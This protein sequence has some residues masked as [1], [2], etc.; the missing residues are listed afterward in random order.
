[1]RGLLLFFVLTYYPVLSQIDTLIACKPGNSTTNILDFSVED[2]LY[3]EVETASK[4]KEKIQD[5]PGIITLITGADIQKMDALN[6]LQV[7][8]RLVSV[9]ITGSVLFPENVISIRGD[10]TVHY[11]NHVL[12][13]INGRPLRESLGGGIR[14]AFYTQFPVSAIQKIEII[15]GPGSVLYGTGAFVGVVNV[16]TNKVEKNQLNAKVSAG[17][18]Q[19][20]QPQLHALLN[21]SNIS[22]NFAANAVNDNGWPFTAKDAS[23]AERTINMAQ[24]GV[25]GYL[26]VNTKQLTTQ[27]YYGKSQQNAMY[28][29]GAWNT[30]DVVNKN[31]DTLKNQP[32]DYV[33]DN[34]ICFADVGY[35][36]KVNQYWKSDVN[37]T[38]NYMKIN[39]LA[40][41]AVDDIARAS[42][43]DV[44][45]EITQY[46][47]LSRYTKWTAGAVVGYNSGRQVF[48]IS[49][50]LPKS[51]ENPLGLGGYFSYNIFNKNL[52]SNPNPYNII[53]PY[54]EWWQAGYLQ[55]E[56]FLT[57]KWKVVMGVQANKAPKILIDFVPRF[58]LL[59]NPNSQFTIKLLYGRAFRFAAANE[60]FIKVD[61]V[62]GNDK[63]IPEKIETVEWGTFW[64]NE[65][66]NIMIGNAFFYSRQFNRI[67]R[68]LQFLDSVRQ[69][70]AYTN[71][72]TRVSYGAEPEVTIG[73]A[74]KWQ[75]TMNALL[76]NSY[77]V[78]TS[79]ISFGE[80]QTTRIVNPQ[81]MPMYQIKV[82]C[83]WQ[84]ING[85][86]VNAFYGFF[87]NNAAT[88]ANKTTPVVNPS[89]SNMH[90]LNVSL[91]CKPQL[92]AKKG[93]INYYFSVSS[94]NV[95][96]QKMYMPD[97]QNRVNSIPARSGRVVY[98]H[99]GV[100]I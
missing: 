24:K 22:V 55:S 25:G 77:D 12:V 98:F 90:L 69:Q 75:W 29:G 6:L 50:T 14:M 86:G 96:N 93:K 100:S 76:M 45:A 68:N 64:Q 89:I 1:M 51:A 83:N 95:L 70:E 13:L 17:S 9:Y 71:E 58:T 66:G 78:Q 53:P 74:A 31:G 20:W 8:E 73:F 4:N 23:S 30:A 2:M 59:Y 5:A 18:F 49:V 40:V 67:A 87:G 85:V 36:F 79:T 94:Q 62:Q 56:I 26:A 61:F 80:T 43:N 7:L 33:A 99:V 91:N 21:K 39:E 35:Q 10:A 46:F 38:Y 47:Q 37:I 48:P 60:R 54:G 97:L 42:T 88:P 44:Q 19:R 72:G 84:P 81:R 15:R 92:L 28:F 11:N 27:F 52:G 34:Q 65:K 41:G 57:Q 63:L 32:F 16:I 82:S 3:T